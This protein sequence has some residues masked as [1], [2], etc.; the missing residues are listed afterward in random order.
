M[1]E[2]SSPRGFHTSSFIVRQGGF[3]THLCTH[4]QRH[5][6]SLPGNGP[7]ITARKRRQGD[8]RQHGFTAQERERVRT[9]AAIEG[10]S[11]FDTFNSAK[12]CIIN[13]AIGGRRTGTE[14]LFEEDMKPQRDMPTFYPR[15]TTG[16]A[17]EISRLRSSK[18]SIGPCKDSFAPESRKV[19]GLR[20]QLGGFGIA[21]AGV[22]RKTIALSGKW[23]RD[24]GSNWPQSYKVQ[25]RAASL[26]NHFYRCTLN[27]LSRNKLSKLRMMI[28]C[29]PH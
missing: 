28:E 4:L 3:D 21:T 19:Y 11:T 20:E 26:P 29:I 1:R 6:I 13:G 18:T 15:K 25:P 27:L 14:R 12:R 9:G 23:R 22:M 8:A 16:F 2:S 5:A 17:T 10:W 7:G 24:R